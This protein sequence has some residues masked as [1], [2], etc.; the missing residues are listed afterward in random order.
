MELLFSQFWYWLLQI[1]LSPFCRSYSLI[2]KV[3]HIWV[4]YEMCFW[5]DCLSNPS[6][7]LWNALLAD[8]QAD[9]FI[10]WKR[11]SISLQNS[12][13]YL[14]LL[15]RSEVGAVVGGQK[16]II[17]LSFSTITSP[18][19][20]DSWTLDYFKKTFRLS[21]GGLHLY[22]AVCINACFRKKLGSCHKW[23]TFSKQ[24]VTHFFGINPCP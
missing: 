23:N 5:K 21:R 1:L 16:N 24:K 22:F 6:R 12:N 19:R 15:S 10:C 14:E 11:P 3:S 20:I 18:C 7:R 8:Q 13:S 17:F 4:P 2:L 9:I